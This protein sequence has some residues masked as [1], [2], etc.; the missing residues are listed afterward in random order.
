MGNYLVKDNK[1]KLLEKL[2]SYEPE[3]VLKHIVTPLF[4]D[5]KVKIRKK[6]KDKRDAFIYLDDSDNILLFLYKKMQY[7]ELK[8]AL[9]ISFKEGQP[10]KCYVTLFIDENH[11]DYLSQNSKEEIEKLIQ[12]LNYH[13][14]KKRLFNI[15]DYDYNKINVDIPDLNIQAY[16]NMKKFA[17]EQLKIN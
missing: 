6:L 17:K 14:G 10:H 1:S 9:P 3:L 5:M 2:Y 16:S 4:D 11:R 13:D 15:L 12:E 7:N 8:R